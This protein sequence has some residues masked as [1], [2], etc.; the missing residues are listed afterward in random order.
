MNKYIL[1]LVMIVF[2]S[3]K[4][5]TQTPANTAASPNQAT[6]TNPA[7]VTTGT[8]TEIVVDEKASSDK[9]QKMNKVSEGSKISG[10]KYFDRSGNEFSFDDYKGKTVILD[11]WA[12]WCTPCID[13]MPDFD[14]L[15][16][17][18]AANDKIAFVKV[19]VDEDRK[20]W[21][22]YVKQKQ[23]AEN[24]YWV[25]RDESNPL[26]WLCYKNIA[27]EGKEMVLESLPRYVIIGPDGTVIDK[28]APSPQTKDLLAT[29]N[30]LNI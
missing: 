29:I 13:A 24:S 16:R 20:G 12:T 10:A 8:T 1:I 4:E 28:E 17:D 3:C 9:E 19:S 27:Y 7:P 21:E 23:H 22:D 25:G 15:T 2:A 5:N 14:K 30:S 18:F 11:M 26:F 6:T